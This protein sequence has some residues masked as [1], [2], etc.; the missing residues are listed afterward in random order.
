MEEVVEIFEVYDKDDVVA[1]RIDAKDMPK[2]LPPEFQLKRQGKSKPMLLLFRTKEC[3]PK[4]SGWL[5][6]WSQFPLNER[7]WIRAG[8]SIIKRQAELSP[9]LRALS[10]MFH[11]L[12]PSRNVRAEYFHYELTNDLKTEFAKFSSRVQIELLLV[13]VKMQPQ[14]QKPGFGLTQLCYYAKH[15]ATRHERRKREADE[16][17]EKA[18]AKALPEMR[19]M[20]ADRFNV[21]V[22]DVGFVNVGCWSY[23][24]EVSRK[25]RS[26]FD[27]LTYSIMSNFEG[28]QLGESAEAKLSAPIMIP[29]QQRL[30]QS[31]MVQTKK[32]LVRIHEA[33]LS[34]VINKD[35]L[36][37]CLFFYVLRFIRMQKLCGIRYTTESILSRGA[38]I[39]RNE[40]HTMSFRRSFAVT[41]MDDA[42]KEYELDSFF[43]N[44]RHNEDDY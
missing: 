1:W 41:P 32:L 26:I 10:E 3:D 17:S 29:I 18:R 8:E 4:S 27:V 6:D 20:Q 16:A 34:G 23:T 14:F 40:G 15:I 37:R 21:S 44:R 7:R 11:G 19:M 13:S 35:V 2:R 42:E 12:K 25:E 33:Q 38:W 39:I 30:R 31:D 43:N 24:H 28:S 36:H 5:E 22:D 9:S